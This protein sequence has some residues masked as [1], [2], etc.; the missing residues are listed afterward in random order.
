MEDIVKL[1]LVEQIKERKISIRNLHKQMDQICAKNPEYEWMSL[2]TLDRRMQDPLSIQDAELRLIQ[3][4]IEQI[5]SHA[6]WIHVKRNITE[7]MREK[8]AHLIDEAMSHGFA[9]HGSLSN[10]IDPYNGDEEFVSQVNGFYE[11]APEECRRHWEKVLP[12]YL[13]LPDLAKA[14]ILCA[15]Y[16]GRN[17]AENKES[18]RRIKEF[19]DCFPVYWGINLL[20]GMDDD[21]IRQLGSILRAAPEYTLNVSEKYRGYAI[22][23]MNIPTF[24]GQP[25]PTSAFTGYAIA[26][27]HSVTDYKVDARDFIHGASFLLYI[28]KM[29]WLLAY[30]S[31]I[32]SFKVNQLDRSYSIRREYHDRGCTGFRFSDPEL[33]YLCELLYVMKK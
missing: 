23:R 33:D 11:D 16:I 2:S 26:Y 18:N 32:F 12:C 8:Y 27:K 30:A 25:K 7:G 19:L 5:L 31:S 14:S 17:D 20:A 22:D 28:D 9:L 15:S 4:A 21:S 6:Q 24:T 3:Q 29:E 13:G 10:D 1:L